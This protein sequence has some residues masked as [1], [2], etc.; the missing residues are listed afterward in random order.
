MKLSC[1]FHKHEWIL[2]DP[3]YV[4]Q[5]NKTLEY[6][7][8]SE[9]YCPRCNKKQDLLILSSQNQLDLN[10]GDSISSSKTIKINEISSSQAMQIY[11]AMVEKMQFL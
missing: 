6:V 5:L 1:L 9:A 10:A 7:Y 11:L 3:E 4:L 2:I 8:I